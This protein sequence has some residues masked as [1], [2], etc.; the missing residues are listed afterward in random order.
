MRFQE[1]LAQADDDDRREANNFRHHFPSEQTVWAVWSVD[2]DFPLD[3]V[4]GP[5]RHVVVCGCRP[6]LGL[7]FGHHKLGK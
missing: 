6:E 3:D 7:P 4:E 2:P 5:G 1:W